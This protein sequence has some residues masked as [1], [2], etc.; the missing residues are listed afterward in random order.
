MPYS[1][2]LV[3]VRPD[4]IANAICSP[5]AEDPCLLK[6]IRSVIS[7]AVNKHV[8][9]LLK[10]RRIAGTAYF[11]TMR[12]AGDKDRQARSLGKRGRMKVCDLLFLPILGACILS[13]VGCSEPQAIV[14][15]PAVLRNWSPQDEC[16]LAQALTSYPSDSVLW[17]LETDWARM[18]REIGSQP[19][20][21]N[22]K[23]GAIDEAHLLS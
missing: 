2:S 3:A 1:G 12:R 10:H 4:D 19:R 18:R 8:V 11:G 5:Q 20:K 22:F 21:N 13:L 15:A 9:P 17:T 16:A 6:P 23:C 14:T 7:D